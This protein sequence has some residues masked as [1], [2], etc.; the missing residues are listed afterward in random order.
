MSRRREE[1]DGFE[2]ALS[3]AQR[4]SSGTPALSVKLICPVSLTSSSQ[5]LTPT[6]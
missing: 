3:V 1:A 6:L 2:M 5:L 4:G